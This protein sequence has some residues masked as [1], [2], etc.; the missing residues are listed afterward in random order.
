MIISCQNSTLISMPYRAR[1]GYRRYKKK[2]T[3]KSTRRL[4]SKKV[5]RS[6][7]CKGEELRATT[8][9]ASFSGLTLNVLPGTTVGYINVWD[10]SEGGLQTQRLGKEIAAR[11]VD[12]RFQASNPA[13]A[14]YLTYRLV[15]AEVVYGTQYPGSFNLGVNLKHPDQRDLVSHIYYD[16]CFSL[17]GATADSL[18]STDFRQQSRM[19]VITIPCR[20]HLKWYDDT[21]T[22]FIH[23]RPVLFIYTD[24]DLYLNNTQVIGWFKDY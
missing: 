23:S 2:A 1:K 18:T 17:G 14:K 16:R 8:I 22:S 4:P 11:S 10:M 24:Q 13:S 7:V 19:H 9:W 20:K 21:G 12:V 6:I 3:R 15:L 5:C